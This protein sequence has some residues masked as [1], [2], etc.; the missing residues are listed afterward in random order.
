MDIDFAKIMSDKSDTELINIVTVD[1]AKY[2][3]AAIEAAKKEIESRNV[4]VEKIQEISEKIVVEKQK[5]A[6]VE[7]NTVNTLVR[8]ANFLIDTILIFIAYGLIVPTLE[9]FIS[10]SST[11]QLG[12]YR[13]GTLVLFVMCYYVAFEHNSQKTIGK[14]ITKTKV[15]NL[16]GEK[17]E[18]GDIISRSLCRFIP[19][20]RIS[21]FFSKNGFHDKVS[22]T[23]VI[24]D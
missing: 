12:I 24:K 11:T 18:L 15:V 21:F 19:F 10:F 9:Y 1:S 2:Q 4:Q 13:I 3:A 8:L 7:N 14:M 20:D 22:G 23:K 16:Q 6:T 5:L 17:P